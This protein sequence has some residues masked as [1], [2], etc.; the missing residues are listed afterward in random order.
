MDN[1]RQGLMAEE[2]V[3]GIGDL[4]EC[5]WAAQEAPSILCSSFVGG[6]NI[7]TSRRQLALQQ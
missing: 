6:D 2:H 5:T 4:H 3:E 7:L 1:Y